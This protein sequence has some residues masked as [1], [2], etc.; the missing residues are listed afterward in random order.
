MKVLSDTFYTSKLK[1]YSIIVIIPLLLYF[2]SLFYDFSPM[3]EQWLIIRRQSFLG[4]FNNIFKSFSISIQN[5]YYRPLFISSLILDYQIDKTNPFM[6]HFTNILLH[7]ICTVCVFIFL[8]LIKTSI[9]TAFLF[10]IFFSVHPAL[11]NSVAWIPGRNDT[12]LCFF[13]L[14]S[15]ISLINYLNTR[16]I[17]FIVAHLVFYVFCLLTKESAILLPVIFAFIIFVFSKFNKNSVILVLFWLAIS[18]GWL[19]VRNGIISYFPASEQINYLVSLKDVVLGFLLFIGKAFLPV[20]QSISPTISN[21]Y[22]SIILGIIAIILM[23]LACFKTGVKDKKMAFFG[24]AIFFVSLI[25]P[26]WY[27]ALSP[28]GVQ[29]EHRIYTALIGL[30]IFITQF[31]IDFNSA[32]FKNIILVTLIIFSAK[33]FIRMPIYKNSASYLEEGVKECPDNYFFQFQTGVVNSNN[34]NFQEAILYF[35]QALELRPDRDEI[36]QHRG[37]AYMSLK[38]YQKAI[39]DFNSGLKLSNNNQNLLLP[40]CIS[41]L[42]LN[43]IDLAFQDLQILKQCCQSSIPL[44][45]EQE[46]LYKWNMYSFQKINNLI[47]KTPNTAILYVNRAKLFI[48]N[49]MGKEALA[50]LKKACELEPNNTVFKSYFDELNRS[51]PQ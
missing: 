11:L 5:I 23:L 44:Q 35:N 6:F 33:S 31:K 29:Y 48:D 13:T 14:I 7:V 45:L 24:L 42:R 4:D 46:I 25:I 26:V 34:K 2:K 28:N 37:S 38:N 18:F 16:K 50:D 22:P 21:S 30:L 47:D 3:D 36:F 32:K 9:K 40:R 27:G 41:Y 39:D 12:M 19:T 15:F 43:Q 51:F 49:R 10:T 20:S 8:S 1:I 17:L